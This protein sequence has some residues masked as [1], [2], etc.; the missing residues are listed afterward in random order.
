MFS[1]FLELR[2]FDN[3][4]SDLTEDAD[5]LSRDSWPFGTAVTVPRPLRLCT[6]IRL[7]SSLPW[8][9][10]SCKVIRLV[11]FRVWLHLEQ[12]FTGNKELSKG[13]ESAD[14]V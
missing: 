12:V 6:P 11:N 14:G 10:L 5:S 3:E 4:R 2:A 9:C 13:F 1:S 7:T 8:H